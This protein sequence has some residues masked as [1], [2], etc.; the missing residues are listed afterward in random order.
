MNIFSFL[1]S[2]NKVA[3]IVG[4]LVTLAIGYELYLMM[5]RPRKQKVQVPDFHETDIKGTNFTPLATKAAPLPQGSGHGQS[6]LM[7]YIVIALFILAGIIV[8]GVIYM[9]VENSQ[10]TSVVSNK[11]SVSYIESS[12]IYLYD[13][14]W[15]ALSDDMF[16][17]LKKGDSILIGIKTIDG[18]D[19]DKARLRV[20]QQEWLDTDETTQFDQEHGVYYRSY[21]IPQEQDAMAIEAELHSAVD[22]WL[23]SNL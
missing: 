23:S 8:A 5:K 12:G 4:I 7:M 22:G 6:Q 16:A 17:S 10:T 1:V 13:S 19:I 15:N 20:N 14:S 11:P 2:V 3:L 21:T 9:R 18:T